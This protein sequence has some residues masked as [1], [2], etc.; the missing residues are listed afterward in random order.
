MHKAPA[1]YSVR[2]VTA[3]NLG[4]ARSGESEM[5]LAGRNLGGDSIEMLVSGGRAHE[6]GA[7]QYDCHGHGAG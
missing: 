4:G 7:I 5:R 3:A 2:V 1:I 6:F